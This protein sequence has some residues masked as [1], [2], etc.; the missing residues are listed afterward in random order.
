MM[1]SCERLKVVLLLEEMARR[2]AETWVPMTAAV[3]SMA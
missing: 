3:Q 2:V 1:F